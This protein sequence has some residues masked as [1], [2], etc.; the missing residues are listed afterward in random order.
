[1]NQQLVKILCFAFA[2]YARIEAM[3]AA[4][5]ARIARD[6]AIAYPENEFNTSASAL[7]NLALEAANL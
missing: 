3:K 4:N 2:E 5:Q 7:Y 6:E 1:M